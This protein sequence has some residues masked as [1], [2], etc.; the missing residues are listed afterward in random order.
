MPLVLYAIGFL[1]CYFLFQLTWLLSLLIAFAAPA[2]LGL[3]M[4][5][6]GV[7]LGGTMLA[8]AGLFNGMRGHRG[9][10]KIN[11]Q[12]LGITLHDFIIQE[13]FRFLESGAAKGILKHFS[14]DYESLGDE[15]TWLGQFAAYSS[16]KELFSDSSGDVMA[17]VAEAYYNGLR[18]GG[19]AEDDI[20]ELDSYLQKRFFTLALAEAKLSTDEFDKNLG[21]MSA[22]SLS[23]QDPP[24]DDLSPVLSIYY[25]GTRAQIAAILSGVQLERT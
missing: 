3:V 6:V 15:L 16:L 8:V 4:F 2:I 20:V 19:I 13:A 11:A 14:L 5:L 9:K 7:P 21:K 23:G 25:L 10:K 17:S 1:V 18:K 24:P 12:G 22:I